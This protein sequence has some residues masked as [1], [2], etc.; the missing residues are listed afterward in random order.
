[1]RATSLTE[2][3]APVWVDLR[4]WDTLSTLLARVAE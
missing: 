4:R 2:A 3:A 1:V